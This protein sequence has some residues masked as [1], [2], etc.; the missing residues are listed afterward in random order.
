ME[1]GQ[2][3]IYGP[4]IVSYDVD[5]SQSYYLPYLLIMCG[6][7]R[8]CP[9]KKHA[10]SKPIDHRSSFAG[11]GMV[12]CA[13]I[14]VGSGQCSVKGGGGLVRQVHSPGGLRS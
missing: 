4:V 7:S 12:I 13:V 5:P 6:F 3:D 8:P 9:T 14:Q 2:G 1:V 11:K 10:R